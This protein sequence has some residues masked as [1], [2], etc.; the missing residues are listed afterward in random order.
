[1]QSARP[2]E[3]AD[4]EQNATSPMSVDKVASPPTRSQL[5]HQIRLCEAHAAGLDPEQDAQL[6][7]DLEQRSLRLKRRISELNPPAVQLA[8]LEQAITRKSDHILQL[9][10]QIQEMMTT[11]SKHEEAL[12]E[13]QRRKTELKGMLDATQEPQVDPTQVR[14]A[15]HL[16]HQLDESEK[17]SRLLIEILASIPNMPDQ[18]KNAI[19]A[20]RQQPSSPSPGSLDA[21]GAVSVQAT[22][23]PIFVDEES[24]NCLPFIAPPTPQQA[25]ASFLQQDLDDVYSDAYSSSGF[26]PAH[27][28]SNAARV[29]P[30]VNRGSAASEDQ[31]Q[32][33]TPNSQVPSQVNP[34][35]ATPPAVPLG[36]TGEV[37]ADT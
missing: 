4:G 27:S 12:N 25:A 35:P 20:Y 23:S 33:P 21:Q 7:A 13:M 28:Q 17:R 1:M 32:A 5:S 16:Q 10:F 36:V 31:V 2:Q 9:E 3:A 14:I 18:A 24:E 30:M 22:P 15:E 6:L 26:G 8:N 37:P 19:N 29:S 34:I 11:K